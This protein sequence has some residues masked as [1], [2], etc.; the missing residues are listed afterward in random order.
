MQRFTRAF[1]IATVLASPAFA[2]GKTEV[3]WWG[4]AAWIIKTPAGTTIAIDPWLQNPK[5]PAD[6]K[7]PEALDAILVSH[8]HG[9]HVGNTIDLAKKTGAKILGSY[10]LANLLGDA[11]LGGNIG[12]TVVIKD[13]TV[14]YVEA[15]HSS[16]YSADGKP[17][18]QDGGVAMG[19]IIEIKDGPTLYHAGDTGLFQDMSLIGSVY[20]P[21]YAM[22]PIGGHFTMDPALAAKAAKMLNV[23]TVIPMHFGTFPVLTGTPDE[24]RAALKKEAPSAKV[25]EF[26]PGETKSL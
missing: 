16:G 21:Q 26:K 15:V 22:L 9:D 1:L 14:H 13:V 4:H 20:K 11:S 7:W 3:T 25:L 5:A 23:K 17:P 12:G 19:F 24:L 18:F 10:E 6:A 8:A 2:A